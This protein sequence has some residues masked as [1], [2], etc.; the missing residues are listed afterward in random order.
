M[1][2]SVVIH[3]STTSP[4]DVNSRQKTSHPSARDSRHCIIIR[5]RER[6]QKD[7]AI[8]YSGPIPV[9]RFFV[10]PCPALLGVLGKAPHKDQCPNDIHNQGEICGPHH[11]GLVYGNHFGMSIPTFAVDIIKLEWCSE[12]CHE[13][14]IHRHCTVIR[15]N[16]QLVNSGFQTLWGNFYYWQTAYHAPDAL[17]ESWQIT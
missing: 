8:E 14:R 2:K 12:D 6:H 16:K 3:A 5:I 4:R 11:A 10:R 17:D 7:H 9:P 1:R 13:S 15:R